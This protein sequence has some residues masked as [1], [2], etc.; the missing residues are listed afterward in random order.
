MQSRMQNPLAT[1]PDALKALLAL[2]GAVEKTGL[3]HK[4][5]EL[6]HLRAS[7]INGCG[8][9][10]D[11]HPR[12]AK[13]HGE[14]DERLHAVAAWRETPYFTPAERVALAITEELT[15]LA[16]RPGALPDALWLE[17]RQHYDEKQLSGLIVT[18]GVIN[19][20]NRVNVANREMVDPAR[21]WDFL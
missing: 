20:F 19:V 9:C 21:K 10:C 18:I 3:P 5:M 11:L 4:T 17:A 13:K 8:V 12:I 2:S 7:Q 14:T 1:L 15:R 16:D 6:V